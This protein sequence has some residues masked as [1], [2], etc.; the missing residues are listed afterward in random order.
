[1][2]RR[3]LAKKKDISE[4]KLEQDLKELGFRRLTDFENSDEGKETC[5]L[6]YSLD[7]MEKRKLQ[8]VFGE[9]IAVFIEGKIKR[10]ITR[11]LPQDWNVK[12][13]IHL[14]TK[15]NHK[16]LNFGQ[17][18]K[19]SGSIKISGDTVAHY[20]AD[21][22]TL[23]ERVQQRHFSASEYLF[24]KF[25][26]NQIPSIDNTFYA[27]KKSGEKRC[28]KYDFIDHSKNS[29]QIQ[30]N[31]TK[32]SVEHIED[33]KVIGLEV[34]TTKSDAKNLLSK[35][36]R[37]IRERA[38]NSAFLD[39]YTIDVDFEIEESD[40]PTEIPVKIKKDD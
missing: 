34:K 29:Y 5:E 33:F 25:Q 26:E 22:E 13:N 37:R 30:R 15:D 10:F 20:G 21:E 23:I 32:V 16:S 38:Q 3:E 12:K 6:E 14:R 19:D 24:N 36:Q 27:L 1:M 9:R 40:I 11:I 39:F 35:K 18:P 4:A 8:G 31:T 2:N 7:E 28:F 17:K